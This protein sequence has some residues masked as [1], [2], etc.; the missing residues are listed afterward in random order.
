M[1][2]NTMDRFL[3]FQY[4]MAV[5]EFH[6]YMGDEYESAM[7]TNISGIIKAATTGIGK[8][9]MFVARK[10]KDAAKELIKIIRWKWSGI[11]MSVTDDVVSKETTDICN[12]CTELLNTS[13]KHVWDLMIDT[14]KIYTHPVNEEEYEKFQDS[15]KETIDEISATLDQLDKCIESTSDIADTTRKKSFRDGSTKENVLDNLKDL[16]HEWDNIESAAKTLVDNSASFD[17]YNELLNLG[18]SNEAMQQFK[19]TSNAI[20][21][22]AMRCEKSVAALVSFVN[23]QPIAVRKTTFRG[24]ELKPKIKVKMR[25]NK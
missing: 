16:T 11:S 2:V 21:A 24:E 5:E 4:G 23:S 15:A 19:V 8:A 12:Q 7:E 1:E 22:I 9:V 3:D 18:F 13:S 6:Y 17:K 10:I 14:N 25:P 20:A